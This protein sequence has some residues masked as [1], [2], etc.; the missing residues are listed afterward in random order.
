VALEWMAAGV[1][2]AVPHSGGLAEFC[3]TSNSIPISASRSGVIECIQQFWDGKK[4]KTV[5]PRLLECA[6][7]TAKRYSWKTV[8]EKTLEIYVNTN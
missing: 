8:A 6:K 2:L 7:D 4:K 1:P 5:S 3:N